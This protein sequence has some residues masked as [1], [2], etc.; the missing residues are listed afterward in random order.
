MKY[1]ILIL[2]LSF[3][4]SFQSTAKTDFSW[5]MVTQADWDIKADPEKHIEDA[6][7]IFEKII[8]DDQNMIQNK[9][10]YELYRRIRILSDK[11]REWA[12]VTVPYLA[13][14]QKVER[15]NARTILPDNKMVD[16][17]PSQIF[18]KE[19]FKT[20]G[21]KIK[22]KSFS[23]PAV[24]SDCIIEYYIKFRLPEPENVWMIEKD[25]YLKRGVLQ[26]KFYRGEGISD[27]V[28]NELVEFITPNYLFR[29]GDRVI[30]IEKRPSIKAAEE[31]VF[32]IQEVP[33]FKSES[34][35]LPD[36]AIKG[37]LRF[38]YGGNDSPAAYWG[39]FHKTI[40]D[41][42]LEFTKKNNRGRKIVE[43]F[44]TLNSEKEKITAAYTWLQKNINNISYLETAEKYKTNKSVD[45]V[46]KN[47]Y[48]TLYEINKTFYD[49]LRE[50][51][52]DAKIA[53]VFDR[54]ENFFIESAKYWQ[55]DRAVVAVPKTLQD[56]DFYN[57]GGKYLPVGVVDWF[58]EGTSAFVIGDLTK[59]FFL[60][61]NSKS[62]FNRSDI[63][64]Q[65]TMDPNF[66]I[67]C[68]TTIRHKG[69]PARSIRLRLFQ[70][71]EKEKEAY[72]QKAFSGLYPNCEVDSL[73]VEGLEDIAQ[74]V[75]LK[76]NVS[77]AHIG[78]VMG[79]RLLIKP[80]DF[81]TKYENPF[82]SEAR[83]FSVIFDYAKETNEYL[84]IS[85]PAEWEIEAMPSDSLFQNNVGRYQIAF[86]I[87]GAGKTISVQRKY[88]LNHPFWDAKGYKQVKQLY[89]TMQIFDGFTVVLKKK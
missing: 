7:M 39:K 22:Q 23:L 59:Q 64:Q 66:N 48:G 63:F 8:T 46:L 83:K 25:I 40:N 88:T 81:L 13:K 47:G 5:E 60:I 67:N 84:Q 10:Y 31:V 30:N 75:T 57:P 45:D 37:Q 20:E 70:A 11:G 35:T 29:F 36:I 17:D 16:L 3:C 50:M 12:D 38:Y 55:F 61:E 26:W 69:H 43:E 51:N 1:F 65:I 89:Q 9:C 18:E 4:F 28:Y 24:S 54:D 49:M 87:L 82:Q 53:F 72:L 6:V 19:V 41:E 85:L 32:S 14:E 58:T 42:L 62:H 52:I 79:D 76:G 78:Q 71:N 77:F 33:A 56:Y 2:I 21:I 34:Y 73:K 68:T 44:N 27:E 86:D 80:A 74:D 15:I